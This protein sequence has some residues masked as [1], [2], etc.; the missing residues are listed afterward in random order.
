MTSQ[1]FVS[2]ICRAVYEPTEDGIP[3]L[4]QDGPPGRGPSKRLV[5]LSRWFNQLA[6]EDQE[7][8]RLV[9][10]M[11]AGQAIF[12]ML[13]V[14]DGVKSIRD[15]GEQPGKL[16]L[17]YNTEGQSFL[18]NSPTGELLHDLFNYEVP[19]L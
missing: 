9:V 17:R 13:T 6:A 5:T 19:P 12:G 16:E 2:K 3:A 1:E 15:A 10:Q 14:L 18:L 11:S 7:C 4:L 8:V